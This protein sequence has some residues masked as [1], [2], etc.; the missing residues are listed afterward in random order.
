MNVLIGSVGPKLGLRS[1]MS[2]RSENMLT[3]HSCPCSISLAFRGLHLTT[4]LTDS[5]ALLRDELE[6]VEEALGVLMVSTPNC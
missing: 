6:V 1:S 5:I 3:Q 4:T 2:P